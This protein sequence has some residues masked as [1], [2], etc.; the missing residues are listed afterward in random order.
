METGSLFLRRDTSCS[1]RYVACF[2]R[3]SN[4]SLPNATIVFNRFHITKMVTD[5]LLELRKQL[6]QDETLGV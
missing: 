3:R 1:N 6:Y 4:Q 2:H 5:A